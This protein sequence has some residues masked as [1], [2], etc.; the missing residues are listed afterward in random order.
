[1]LAGRVR[2]RISEDGSAYELWQGET[3]LRPIPINDARKDDKLA[4]AI[5]RNG[6]GA[7]S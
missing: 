3:L 4:G 7:L 2:G 5:K 6:W 1:M